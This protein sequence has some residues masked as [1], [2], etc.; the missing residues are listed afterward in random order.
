MSNNQI[1]MMI[2]HGLKV[3]GFEC[4]WQNLTIRDLVKK[5]TGKKL[6]YEGIFFTLVCK[7][8]PKSWITCTCIIYTMHLAMGTTSWVARSQK[9][10]P[11]IGPSTSWVAKLSS[12]ENIFPE[13]KK[14]PPGVSWASGSIGRRRFWGGHWK[15]LGRG[16]N[17]SRPHI[18][19]QLKN[20]PPNQ[21]S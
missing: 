19:P 21:V 18:T 20:Y 15:V 4:C 5:F 6:N 8:V 1:Y 3:F 9:L 14:Q 11:I 2:D 12:C 17:G 13:R 10:G 16:V 7:F